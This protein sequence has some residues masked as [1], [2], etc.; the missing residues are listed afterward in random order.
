MIEDFLTHLLAVNGYLPHGYCISWQPKL[1]FTFVVSDILSFLSY[2]SMPV[3]LIYYA[4]HRHNFP[5]KGLFWLFSTFIV[6][7]GLTHLMDAIVLWYPL[8]DLSAL[9]KAITAFVSVITAIVIW[10]LI[11]HALKLPSPAELKLVNEKLQDEI[12]QRKLIEEELRIAKKVAEEGLLQEQM[13]LAAIV[14]SSEDAIVSK[15]LEGR[16]TTWNHTAEK[17]FGYKAEE[18]IGQFI[19]I[20]IPPEKIDEEN[21]ILATIAHGEAIKHYRTDRVCKDGR[22][23]TVSETISPIFDKEGRIVGASKIARDISDIIASEEAVKTSESRFRRLFHEAPVP[24]CYTNEEG[25]LTDFNR[26]FEQTFGYGHSDVPTMTEWWQLA[27]PD[28]SYRA[29]VMAIWKAAV[30]NAAATG[31]DINP[32]ESQVTCKNGE[33]RTVLISGIVLGK[34][35]LATFFDITERRRAQEE[36]LQLNIN[37]EHRVTE[38]T[39]ELVSANQ[40]LESFAYAVSHDL[41]APL[42]AMS[43]FSQA[44]VEDYG[45]KFKGD[46]KEYLEQIDIASR[47]IGELIDGILALSRSTR[48]ELQRD[49]LDISE[50]AT[51]LF[52][53]FERNGHERKVA[54]YVEPNLRATGDSRMVEVAL[55]NLIANAWK[56]TGKTKAP[57]IS[58]SLGEVE[59]LR[60]FCVTDNGAG[61]DM[62]HSERLFKPFQR[63]HRQDEFPG[64][65]IGLATVQRI[66]NRHGGKIRAKG[67]PGNGATFCFTLS[68]TPLEATK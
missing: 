23:I 56:Y 64:M 25:V 1:L 18:I 13:R 45:D 19:R 36:V 39:S 5:Y 38:R 16:V 30:V 46:A 12:A 8:Y 20:L 55:Q 50:L 62:A 52:K 47:K 22:R 2:I 7:C 9:L 11:P 31:G 54:W 66:I 59:D 17:I 29:Q 60:G 4:R 28:S 21:S 34:E 58:V 57:A 65:G 32:I 14:E 10:P 48:G 61:F 68:T 42:R 33:I 40:E 67:Q 49:S 35:L 63:L 37:L 44:L 41:R 6:A 43:G 53:G 24:L 51:N 15:T 3:A 27:Y 26:H